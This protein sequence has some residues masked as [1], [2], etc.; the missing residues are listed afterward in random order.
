[1]FTAKGAV[2]FSS[3]FAES[4]VR[5]RNTL[6]CWTSTAS[7]YE[8]GINQFFTHTDCNKFITCKYIYCATQFTNDELVSSRNRLFTWSLFVCLFVVYL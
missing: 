2:C 1:M 8:E 5:L 6:I 3:P 7:E 4:E